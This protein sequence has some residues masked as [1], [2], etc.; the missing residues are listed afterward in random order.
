M[1]E[2]LKSDP[3]ARMQ[4]KRYFKVFVTTYTNQGHYGEELENVFC[5]RINSE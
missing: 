5:H 4:K 3:L 2:N 1:K